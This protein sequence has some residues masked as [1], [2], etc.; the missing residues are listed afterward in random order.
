MPTVAEL[1]KRL[2]RQDERLDAFESSQSGM[3]EKMI[4]LDEKMNNSNNEMKRMNDKLTEV[5]ADLKTL[6]LKP[7]KRWDSTTTTIVS[8]V[9]GLI[10]GFVFNHFIN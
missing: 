6:I 1:E 2:D 4:R 7:G 5:S 9:L 10:I 3:N 8:V